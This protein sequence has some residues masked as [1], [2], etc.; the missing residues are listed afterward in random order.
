MVGLKGNQLAAFCKLVH[1]ED[2]QDDFWEQ[3]NILFQDLTGYLPDIDGPVQLKEL[4]T[5]KATTEFETNPSV[6]K[7]DVLYQRP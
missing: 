5:R 2:R 7:I 6:T 4:I 1:F 3:R